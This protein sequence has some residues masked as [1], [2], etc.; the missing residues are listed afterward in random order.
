MKDTRGP[1][2]YTD[3]LR[4]A[5]SDVPEKQIIA[6]Y[7]KELAV[8]HLIRFPVRE[9]AQ[10]TDP[11]PEG[12]E[13]WD[14]GTPI[15]NIDWMG[16]LASSPVVIPGV[17]TKERTY[18]SSPGT[19]PETV[20]VDLY[21]GIDCS[22][23]MGNPSRSLSYPILAASIIALSALRA[24]ANVMVALSGEPG[25][26]VTTD[27]FIRDE[28]TIMTTLTDYLGTG[29]TFGIHRLR[30]TFSTMPVTRRP[31][32]ILIITDNDIFSMLNSTENGV[33][34]WDVAREAVVAARGGATYVLQLPAYLMAQAKAQKQ[35]PEGELRMIRDGWHVSH[36]DNMEQLV[37]FAREFS[38]AKYHK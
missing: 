31:V 23:S 1:V 19:S 17:T 32:H 6:R 16:T 37:E 5:G 38:Q 8:P 22:G 18:G 26:T 28:V 12:L 27:G 20:P 14:S 2:E 3:L 13:V 4:A 33:L 21:L 24:K 29:T 30:P 36:V 9:V 34:G 11:S 15:E 35:I 10:A 25:R 7:Y